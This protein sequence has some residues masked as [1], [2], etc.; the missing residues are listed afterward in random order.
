MKVAAERLHHLTHHVEPHA[1]SRVLVGCIP[2]RKTRQKTE[3]QNLRIGIGGLRTHE[4]VLFP[5][6]FAY[7]FQIDSAS[8]VADAD[9]NLS[10]NICKQKR[11]CTGPRFSCLLTFF[12]PLDSMVNR[13]ADQMEKRIQYAIR[14]LFI[15]LHIL[16]LDA[17]RNLFL[18]LPA[19][20]ADNPSQ[21]RNHIGKRHHPNGYN[22]FLQLLQKTAYLIVFAILCISFRSFHP[23]RRRN[24]QF[25]RQILQLIQLFHPDVDEIGAILR[26]CLGF[27]L[28][29]LDSLPFRQLTFLH[30]RQSR[31]LC[32]GF[33]EQR[34]LKRL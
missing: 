29:L 11:N 20:I 23:G 5:A 7:L 17:E 16:P 32:A 33:H 9:H 21:L 34:A 25:A 28:R 27:G 19:D 1:S 26:R 30:L 6:L 24:N 10:S 14:D 18:F 12:R 3:F 2:R 13:V 22:Q 31:R 4:Q 15:H 8:V